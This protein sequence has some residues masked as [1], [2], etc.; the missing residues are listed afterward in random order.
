MR[1]SMKNWL[2]ASGIVVILL[3]G[4]SRGQ[5]GSG[6][7]PVPPS[8]P[9]G[10]SATAKPKADYSEFVLSGGHPTYRYVVKDGRTAEI[11]Y[12]EL[13]G[14]GAF[15]IP[16]IHIEVFNMGGCNGFLYLTRTRIAYDGNT[17]DD[18]NYALSE[19]KKV[20]SGGPYG[21]EVNTPKKD[22]DFT[23]RSTDG[24]ESNFITVHKPVKLLFDR[25]VTDFDGVVKEFQ[26]ATVTAKEVHPPAVEPPR[27]EVSSSYDRFK[28]VT[29][30][31]LKVT[32]ST[33]KEENLR[34]FGPTLSMAVAYEFRGQV[35]RESPDNFTLLFRYYVF[36]GSR[37][38]PDV[39]S[40][41]PE[42]I[43]IVDGQRIFGKM[44]RQ[45]YRDTLGFKHEL[46]GM[47]IDYDTLKRVAEAQR[48]EMRI[49]TFELE[50]MEPER[51]A[52]REFLSRARP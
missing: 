47:T 34:K 6:V 23:L 9:K 12:V 32:L 5:Q 25:M 30:V 38:L 39:F 4:S 29:T 45:S 21:M 22:Y 52:L 20:K 7:I 37:L 49:G 28:D 17:S 46:A 43:F 16:V 15:V 41:T 40:E 8:A 19:M 50:L 31:G 27:S 35:Q 11:Q 1:R 26:Q 3:S 14:E 48:V 13:N 2:I 18:F 36:E 10:A 51:K 44:Q 42:L 33:P 24:A